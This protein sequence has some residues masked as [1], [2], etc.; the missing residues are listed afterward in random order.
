HRVLERR[1]HPLDERVARAQL[2]AQLFGASAQDV[3]AVAEHRVE[4]LVA[5]G[6]VAVEGADADAGPA[7]DGVERRIAAALEELDA[8]RGD[9]A[10][11]VAPRVGAQ[12]TLRSV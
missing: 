6:E 5:G 3:G 10:L 9:D 11:A 2:R 12:R 1:A 4:Q 7:C 8:G